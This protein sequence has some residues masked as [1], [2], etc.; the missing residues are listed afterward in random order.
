MIL[1][2]GVWIFP[3]NRWTPRSQ[4]ESSNNFEWWGRGIF[5]SK[6]CS[7]MILIR[8]LTRHHFFH[9]Q[10]KLYTK[11]IVSSAK[12]YLPK[13]WVQIL[14]QLAV[15]QDFNSRPRA[16]QNHKKIVKTSFRILATC[17]RWCC[18]SGV[19][20]I[21]SLTV[22]KIAEISWGCIKVKKCVCVVCVWCVRV[23]AW[24]FHNEEI[25]P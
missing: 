12:M 5:C 21:S 13:I 2:E 8:L 22:S 20:S 18:M 24:M 23:R 14:L 15:N 7:L 4:S 16:R 1:C 10:K 6:L 9:V 3:P 17:V 25:K 11:H 19:P